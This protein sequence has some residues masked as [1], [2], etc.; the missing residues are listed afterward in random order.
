MEERRLQLG[1]RWLDVAN[2]ADITTETLRQIRTGAQPMRPLTKRAIE[3]GLI[4]AAGSVDNILAGGEATPVDQGGTGDPD[5]DSLIAWLS[6][7]ASNPNRDAPLRTWARTQ[8][9]QL[10]AIRDADQAEGRARG[11]AEA[12]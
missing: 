2:R 6:R 8:I 3:S 11:E 7:V 1:D 9:E 4:W 5:F 12:G 10:A